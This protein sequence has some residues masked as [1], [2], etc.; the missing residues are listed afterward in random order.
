MVFKGVQN[1]KQ[2]LVVLNPE[3]HGFVTCLVYLHMS[4]L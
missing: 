1:V 2:H 3:V 4:S